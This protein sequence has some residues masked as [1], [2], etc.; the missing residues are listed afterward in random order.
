MYEMVTMEMVTMEMVTMEMV[1][2]FIV[3]VIS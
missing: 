1:D 3:V 2:D